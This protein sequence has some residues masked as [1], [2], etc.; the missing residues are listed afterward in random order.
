[1]SSKRD[2]SSDVCSS[3]L[4]QVRGRLL[5]RGGGD[6]HAEVSECVQY[7]G[8]RALAGM[9]IAVEGDLPACE[10]RD[11]RDETHDRACETAIDLRG[12]IGRASCRAQEQVAID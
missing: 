4:G 11:G 3:D 10:G 12:K 5:P 9:R 1:T 8:H 6:L 2:W 7:R